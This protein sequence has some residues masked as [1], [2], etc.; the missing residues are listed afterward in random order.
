MSQRLEQYRRRKARGELRGDLVFPLFVFG[1]LALLLTGSGL[2]SLGSMLGW[3]RL[4][5]GL[6]FGAV[7]YGMY[8]GQI[9]ARW[10]AAGILA[11]ICAVGLLRVLD[12][13]HSFDSVLHL[14]ASG[15][16][17]AYLTLPSTGHRFITAQH[18]DGH[19]EAA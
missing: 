1:A 14:V 3:V 17:A 7:G 18:T 6:V 15:L 12:G 5:G 2:F 16:G 13:S 19:G 9:W 11:V 4:F 8:R 10:P